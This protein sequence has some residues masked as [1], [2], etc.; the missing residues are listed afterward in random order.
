MTKFEFIATEI[1]LAQDYSSP[2]NFSKVTMLHSL[3]IGI[4][5]NIETY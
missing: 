4:E 1:E 3:K 2:K 5:G